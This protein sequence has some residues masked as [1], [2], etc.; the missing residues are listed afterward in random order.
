MS[1]GFSTPFKGDAAGEVQKL[2]NSFPKPSL[3]LAQTTALRA[4]ECLADLASNLSAVS[5]FEQAPLNSL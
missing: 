5:F 3:F 2:C 1:S 4:V